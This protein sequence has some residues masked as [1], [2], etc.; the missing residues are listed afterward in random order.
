VKERICRGTGGVCVGGVVG[1]GVEAAVA[2]EIGTD[3]GVWGWSVGPDSDVVPGMTVD[4]RVEDGDVADC[5]VGTGVSLAVHAA[6][7][8]TVKSAGN[9]GDRCLPIAPFNRYLLRSMLSSV[10]QPCSDRA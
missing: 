2:V 3:V 9:S 10:C 1:T 4:A 8:N 7:K 6:V 5:D